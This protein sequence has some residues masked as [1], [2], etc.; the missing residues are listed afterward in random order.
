LELRRSTIPIN[1][2][3]EPTD[4]KEISAHS[5]IQEKMNESRSLILL[6]SFFHKNTND[7]PIARE[8]D[9]LL[10]V[11]I[12]EIMRTAVDGLFVAFSK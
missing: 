4:N 2:V 1:P 7:G 8:Y 10:W 3:V 11:V 5:F 12:F 6:Y 9:K